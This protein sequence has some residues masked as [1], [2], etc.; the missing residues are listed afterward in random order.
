MNAMVRRAAIVFSLSAIAAPVPVLAHSVSN[1]TSLT[2]ADPLSAPVCAASVAAEHVRCF[3]QAKLQS[4]YG[5]RVQAATASGAG[6]Y[7][8]SD[9][10]GAYGIA[11]GSRRGQTVAVVDVA[12]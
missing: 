6:G 10:Q 8:P 4:P 9:L 2:A 12:D 7:A 11:T 3:A 5:P 1:G